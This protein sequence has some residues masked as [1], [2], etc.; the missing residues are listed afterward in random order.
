MKTVYTDKYGFYPWAMLF[1]SFVGF[2]SAYSGFSEGDGNRLGLGIGSGEVFLILALRR[3]WNVREAKREG[4][5]PT[6]H[7]IKGND[8]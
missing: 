3:F 1:V 2:W 5:D 4:R 8:C 7:R 6:I